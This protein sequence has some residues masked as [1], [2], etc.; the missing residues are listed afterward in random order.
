MQHDGVLLL[1]GMAWRAAARCGWEGVIIEAER[2]ARSATNCCC[3][4]ELR[5]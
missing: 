4:D 1:E 3:S 5:A 2:Q